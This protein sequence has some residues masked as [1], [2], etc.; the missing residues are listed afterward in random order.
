MKK[1]VILILTLLL[2]SLVIA[3]SETLPD[4]L[5]PDPTVAAQAKTQGAEVFRLLPRGMFE[6]KEGSYS[7]ADNPLGVRGGGAFYSFS[8]RLHSYNKTPQIQLESGQFSV[9]GFYGA[10]YG[11]MADLGKVPLSEASLDL[12]ETRFLA[13]YKPPKL[14]DDIR[15]QQRASH[16]YQ[17]GEYVFKRMLPVVAGHTYLLRSISFGEADILVAFNVAGINADGSVNVIWTKIIEFEKPIMLF[18]TDEELS[19]RIE[20]ILKRR[21]YQ[22]VKFSVAKNEVILSGNLSRSYYGSLMTSIQELRPTKIIN[23]IQFK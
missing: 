22:E 7:D 9:G 17:A 3:Q 4:V 18:Q 5:I 6:N 15:K 10:N 16:N 20:D 19:D 11:F 1:G 12:G 21:D 2:S 8:T 23:Q 13:N 14:H